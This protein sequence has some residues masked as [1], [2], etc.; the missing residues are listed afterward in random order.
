R[1]TGGR[2]PAGRRRRSARGSPWRQ[3]L[4]G[5]RGRSWVVAQA[6]GQVVAA[7]RHRVGYRL[8]GGGAGQPRRAA[9]FG[10]TGVALGFLGPGSPPGS[11][12]LGAGAV[13]L[14]RGHGAARVLVQL[15]QRA[16]GLSGR[17]RAVV[18]QLPR[19]GGASLGGGGVLDDGAARPRRR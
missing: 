1:G 3:V 4:G 10:K 15:G 7:L 17:G 2:G 13:G 8:G 12:A 16:L 18:E 14:P 19:Q 11:I 6:R 5:G 9:A